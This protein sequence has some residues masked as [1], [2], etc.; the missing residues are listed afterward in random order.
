MS[1]FKKQLAGR[2]GKS[3]NAI[4]LLCYCSILE[5]MLDQELTGDLSAQGGLDCHNMTDNLRHKAQVL[6]LINGNV[7]MSLL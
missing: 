6:S 1:I 3:H 5:M 4:T 7:S 2:D